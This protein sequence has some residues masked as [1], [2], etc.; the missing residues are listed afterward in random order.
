MVECDKCKNVVQQILLTGDGV[1]VCGECCENLHVC[2]FCKDYFS[3][4]NSGAFNQFGNFVCNACRLEQD[5][6]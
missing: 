2:I 4:E 1:A 6:V 5:N 3:E